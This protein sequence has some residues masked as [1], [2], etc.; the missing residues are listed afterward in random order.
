MTTL[1][2][3]QQKARE[4]ISLSLQDGTLTPEDLDTLVAEAYQA[5]QEYERQN[6]PVGFLRQFINER[7]PEEHKNLLTDEDI[8]RF[9]NIGYEALTQ[10]QNER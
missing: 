4:E 1:H 6:I 8:M 5:G 2:T 7:T 9:I 10:H 3:L